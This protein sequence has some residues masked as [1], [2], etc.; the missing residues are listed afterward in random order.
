MNFFHSTLLL[1]SRANFSFSLRFFLLIDIIGICFFLSNCSF[2][3]SLS[4]YEWTCYFIFFFYFF[5]C[6]YWIHLSLLGNICIGLLWQVSIPKTTNFSKSG[7]NLLDKVHHVLKICKRTKTHEPL[8]YQKPNPAPNEENHFL[9][10][11]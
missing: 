7:Q 8:N 3:S 6:R 9:V 1:L 4:L 11:V 10:R 2:S 5:F